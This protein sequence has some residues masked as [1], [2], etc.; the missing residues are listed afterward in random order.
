MFCEFV[1]IAEE[2][3]VQRMPGGLAACIEISDKWN[4]IF[5]IP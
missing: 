2:I 5:E 4:I 1:H 3:G